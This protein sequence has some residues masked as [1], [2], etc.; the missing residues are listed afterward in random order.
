MLTSQPDP[1]AAVRALFIECAALHRDDLLEEEERREI[2]S[3]LRPAIGEILHVLASLIA[4]GDPAGKWSVSPDLPGYI[5]RAVG[6]VHVRVPV[7]LF[8]DIPDHDVLEEVLALAAEIRTPDAV[9]CLSGSTAVQ[10]TLQYVGD[11]DFCEYLAGEAPEN[12]RAAG[13]AVAGVTSSNIVPLAVTG[14]GTPP[15]SVSIPWPAPVVGDT[16]VAVTRAMM[17][18]YFAIT[19]FAG[20]LDVTK[21]MIPLSPGALDGRDYS[22][23]AQELPVDTPGGWVPRSLTEPREI[24]SYVAFLRDQV[25]KYS[26]D[27][28][29]K[30]SKRA[31]SLAR[32]LFFAVEADEILTMIRDAGLLLRAAA[33]ARAEYAARLRR[34]YGDRLPAELHDQALATAATLFRLCTTPANDELGSADAIVKALRALPNQGDVKAAVRFLEHFVRAVDEEIERKLH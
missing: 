2:E 15:W 28:P 30:A 18:H 1:H 5:I 9:I 29:A 19:R 24:G 34:E 8:D 33:V 7:H 17:G 10:G 27:N 22:H 25:L 16:E 12:F 20:A 6:D 4:A 11:C 13:A 31:F 3:T 23:P 32:V 26:Q 21:M 14:R